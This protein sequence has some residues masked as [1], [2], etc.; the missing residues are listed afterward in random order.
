MRVTK[1]TETKVELKGVHLC[2]QLCVN[3]V[4]GE[5]VLLQ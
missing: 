1:R 4:L 3:G 5:G 2:C